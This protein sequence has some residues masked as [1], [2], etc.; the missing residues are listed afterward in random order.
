MPPIDH[1]RLTLALF[2]AAATLLGTS[3]CIQ[4]APFQG[5]DASVAELP[6]ATQPDATQP[7]DDSEVS[8]PEVV[9]PD[10]GDSDATDG[11]AETVDIPPECTAA[12]CDCG[13]DEDCDDGL[14]CSDGVCCAPACEDKNCGDD[15]CGGVCGT[16]DGEAP[17]NAQGRCKFCEPGTNV[18][19]GNTAK[20]CNGDGT[21]YQGNAAACG[22]VSPGK[23]ICIGGECVCEENCEGKACGDNGCEGDCGECADSQTCDFD[24][25]CVAAECTDGDPVC[26]PEEPG[27]VFQCEGGLIPEVG[28]QD[29]VFDCGAEGATCLIQTALVDDPG[30]SYDQVDLYCSCVDGDQKCADA[31]TIMICTDG[32][33]TPVAC[34][35]GSGGPVCDEAKKACVTPPEPGDEN[36]CIGKCGQVAECG[37]PC[38]CPPDQCY[39]GVCY[40]PCNEDEIGFSTCW[41]ETV[42]A[43]CQSTPVNG[44]ANLWWT[45]ITCEDD[46]TCKEL[47]FGD[48]TCKDD[49]LEEPGNP[50]CC[51]M[52]AGECGYIAACGGVCG[53]DSSQGY[54]CYEADGAAG[55]CIADCTD[56]NIGDANCWSETAIETCSGYLGSKYWKLTSCSTDSGAGSVCENGSWDEQASCSAGSTGGGDDS[57]ALPVN[58]NPDLNPNQYGTVPSSPVFSLTQTEVDGP[59]TISLWFFNM[60]ADP[61]P[62]ASYAIVGKGGAANPNDGI[63]II[64]A[65]EWILYIYQDRFYFQ[66]YDV[67]GFA[68]WIRSKP[69]VSPISGQWVHVVMSYKGNNK[70]N[71]SPHA[72]TKFWLNGVSIDDVSGAWGSTAEGSNYKYSMP[73]E[74]PL[75]VGRDLDFN[76][77]HGAID[78]LAIF[79]AYVSTSKVEAMSNPTG[80]CGS[81]L[82]DL[83]FANQLTAYWRFEDLYGNATVT[84]SSKGFHDMTLKVPAPP[85]DSQC[86]NV[87]P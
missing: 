86:S 76:W 35:A 61:D 29:S 8:Q 25:Q 1:R 46:H 62:D 41:S 50:A 23:P 82:L 37:G 39:N 24:Q 85:W 11:D 13:G 12:E 55:I 81:N 22:L 73:G 15:G 78:E 10:T 53:C 31:E 68:W 52:K 7:D 51:E 42:L 19:D 26:S 72:Q 20:Q 74:R 9:E 79:K 6:D 58:A 2:L 54:F 30:D 49:D 69:V 28:A 67:D 66:V 34:G 48:A 75:M 71:S 44:P 84:G 27:G 3:S 33:W 32:T 83:P 21:R 59:L 36:C 77:L 5:E 56:F 70:N 40:D 65:D 17:C 63:G 64:P 14:A 45:P 43:K 38:P 80:D 16:C 87:N 60:G 47:A 57:L 18:C 4:A